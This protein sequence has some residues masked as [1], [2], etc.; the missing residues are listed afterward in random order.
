MHAEPK[1]QT[2]LI[3]SI[4]RARNCS[5]FKAQIWNHK[6]W[7]HANVHVEM[8]GGVNTSTSGDNGNR[9]QEGRNG[10]PEVLCT[11]HSA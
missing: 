8:L 11:L 6:V 2:T 4:E 7:S 10:P 5:I 1:H 3:K 9:Q